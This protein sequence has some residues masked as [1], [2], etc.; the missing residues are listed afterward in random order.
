MRFR[1]TGIPSRQPLLRHRHPQRA[2]P[3]EV[4]PV[5]FHAVGEHRAAFVHARHHQQGVA[6]RH[7]ALAPADVLCCAGAQEALSCIAAALL[8]PGDHAVIVLPI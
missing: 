4:Q 8:N 5:P 7:A 6:A 2:P 3:G 1:H